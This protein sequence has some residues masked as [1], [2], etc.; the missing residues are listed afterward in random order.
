MKENVK[1][2]LKRKECE[3]K[4][5]DTKESKRQLSSL[6]FR[7][8]INADRELWK[9]VS[10]LGPDCRTFGV[11]PKL[12]PNLKN[13]ETQCA[14]L[15]SPYTDHITTGI[16]DLGWGCGY[17]NCQMLMSFLEKEKQDG[18]YLLKQVLDIASLQLLLEKAWKEGFDPL[19]AKQLKHHVFKTRKWI[20]TTEV[21][22]LLAY[23][24]IRSTIID[25]HQPGPERL[26]KDMLDWIQSYFTS[27]VRTEKNKKVYATQRPPLYL[28]HQGHSRTIVGIELLKTGRRNLILFD[29]GRRTLRSFKKRVNYTEETDTSSEEEEEEQTPSSCSE[30]EEIDIMGDATPTPTPPPKPSLSQRFL[31]KFKKNHPNLHQHTSSPFYPFRVDDKTIAKHRQYQILVLGQASYH[32]GH[33]TWDPSQGYLV[34]EQEREVMKNV[35][36]LAVL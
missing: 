31:A 16:M 10:V 3:D 19:G 2:A 13:E 25:F 5:V 18:D 22:T 9:T 12:E 21:Y 30:E 7:S 24:G 8:H 14:Y 4:V 32:Q 1:V 35:T 23:L 20:G 15:G 26:H 29:P 34:N 28:Q 27:N 6:P 33:I 17:R 36:S 11:I